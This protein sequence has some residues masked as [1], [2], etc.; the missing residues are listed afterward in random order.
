M[1]RRT[2]PSLREA[3]HILNASGTNSSLAEAPT[4][5]TPDSRNAAMAP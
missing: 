3:P 4:I 5:E 1:P 2:L